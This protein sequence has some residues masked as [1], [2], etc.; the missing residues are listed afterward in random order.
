LAALFFL[1]TASACGCDGQDAERLARVGRKVADRAEAVAA[2][3]DGRLGPRWHA[4][5]AQSEGTL[6]GRVSRRMRWDQALA[7]AEIEVTATGGVVELKGK[8][9]DL[10]QRRRAVELT[11]STVGVEQVKDNLEG[12]TTKE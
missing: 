1:L 11:S 7:G 3:T 8:V 5:L 10:A 2:D 9:Q 4:L 6:E 12:P